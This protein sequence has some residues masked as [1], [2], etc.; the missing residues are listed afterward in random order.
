MG[1][2]KIIAPGTLLPRAQ[3][4]LPF[5]AQDGYSVTEALLGPNQPVH[6]AVAVK[7]VPIRAIA[8]H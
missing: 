2:Y 6:A 5:V 8:I 1:M 4:E 7:Q 3:T